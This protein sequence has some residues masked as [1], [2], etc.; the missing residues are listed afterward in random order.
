[1][2]LTKDTPISAPFAFEG[3]INLLITGGTGTVTLERKLGDSDF[4]P[5]STNITG[6]VAQFVC[7]GGCAYNGT[8][9]ERGVDVTYRLSADLD[10]G[11][12]EYFISRA[13]R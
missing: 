11:E 3:V 1:M 5:L 12:V 7:T 10:S 2:K 4:H 13:K 6:G 8:L 9:E